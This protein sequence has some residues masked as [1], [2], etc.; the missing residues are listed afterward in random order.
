[1]LMY[2]FI[3]IFLLRNFIL[4]ILNILEEVKVSKQISEEDRSKVIQDSKIQCRKLVRSASN[5]LI[6]YCIFNS[7]DFFKEIIL[8]YE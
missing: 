4:N 3:V 6:F 8:L 1:M 5:I 7:Q 2:V